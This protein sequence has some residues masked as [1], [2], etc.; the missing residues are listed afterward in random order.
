VDSVRVSHSYNKPTLLTLTPTTGPTGGGSA[1]AIAGTSL[2]TSGVVFFG[3]SQ[4]ALLF[5]QWTHT[6]VSCSC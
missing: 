3:Q 5:G 1:I 2:G 6:Q 4:C